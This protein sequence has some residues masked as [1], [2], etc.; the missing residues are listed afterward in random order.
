M[1]YNIITSII[2]G[3]GLLVTLG[4]LFNAFKYQGL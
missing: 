2:G 3:F 4:V 1:E